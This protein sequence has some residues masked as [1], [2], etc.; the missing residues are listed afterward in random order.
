MAYRRVYTAKDDDWP[1]MG[2]NSEHGYPKRVPIVR[3]K[4]EF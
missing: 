4:D 2:K 3:V 1:Q